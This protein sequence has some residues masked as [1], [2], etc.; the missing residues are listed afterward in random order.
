LFG[1][2]SYLTGGL[3]EA[4][5][6]SYVLGGLD[7]EKEDKQNA[8]LVQDTLEKHNVK[9]D[10]EIVNYWTIPYKE[11]V[12]TEIVKVSEYNQLAQLLGKEELDLKKDEAVVAEQGIANMRSE[13]RR[14]GKQ[15]R[16]R[17]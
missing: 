3:K 15:R 12:Q 2:Q 9:T 4:N 5:P 16:E 6:Y 11:D 8:Q 1:A 17:R 7:D 10:K 13:E 14:V